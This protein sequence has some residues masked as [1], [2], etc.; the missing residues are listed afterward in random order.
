LGEVSEPL[1]IGDKYVVAI[2][3]EINKEG[4]MSASKAKMMVDPVLRNRKKGEAILKKLGTP[5]SL[6]AAVSAGGQPIRN[7]DTIQFASPSL[8]NLGPEPKVIGYAFDKELAG[9]PVSAPIA[10]NQGVFVLKVGT[11]S[12]KANPGADLDQQRFAQEQQQR[13][14]L[15]Y[16][17]VEELRKLA[18]IKDNRSNFF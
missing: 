9:K 18:S 16:Q 2:V 6:E 7:I 10:G 12:A 11:V 8:P 13:S 4:T 14:M 15:P 17:I 1:P 5:A 3:T